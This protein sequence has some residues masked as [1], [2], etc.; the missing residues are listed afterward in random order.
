MCL[1]RAKR[2][3]ACA[4]DRIRTYAANWRQI[5][6][7]VRLSTP[8][9]QHLYFLQPVTRA[10]YQNRTDVNGLQNRRFA[11]ELRGHKRIISE[12]G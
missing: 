2:R 1:H 9:P 3:S 10:P 4:E 11:T 7:L 6:S 12:G 5:Y 8:P